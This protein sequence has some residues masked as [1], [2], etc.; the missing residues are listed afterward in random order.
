MSDLEAYVKQDGRADLVKQ[1]RAKIKALGITYIYY[2]FA[3]VTGRIVGL[4]EKEL[5]AAI[6][7][8]L[9]DDARRSSMAA[10]CV[11]DA[12]NFDWDLLSE[13]LVACYAK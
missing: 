1:V 9:G 3:S 6:A 4:D 13:R 10:R 5:S 2:Q 11:P 8:L 7:D 12:G